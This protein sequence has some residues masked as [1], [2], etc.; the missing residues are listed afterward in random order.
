MTVPGMHEQP[1]RQTATITVVLVATVAWAL[2]TSLVVPVLPLIQRDLGTDQS[3]AAWV[4]TGYLLAASVAVPI[5]GRVGDSFGKNARWCSWWSCSPS[6]SSLPGCI[7]GGRTDRRARD[8][9]NRRGDLA[10][11]LRHSP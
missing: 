4:V 5:V 1:P 6:A 7:L 3:T 11:R 8:S 10:A 2:L 9:G